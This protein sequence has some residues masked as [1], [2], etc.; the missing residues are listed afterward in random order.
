M[1]NPAFARPS[2]R[3]KVTG[4]REYI[5]PLI[6]ALTLAASILLVPAIVKGDARSDAEAIRAASG[7]AGGFVV[8]LG[9]T[10]GTMTAALR[11]SESFQ[12]QGLV[13]DAATLTKVRDQIRAA[14]IYGDVSADQFAGT[15]LPYVDNLVNLLVAESLGEV[16]ET[17]ALRVLVPN[18][19]LLVK[20][21][22]GEWTKTIKPRPADID[23]WSHYLHDAS[24][25]AVA[26]DKQVAPPRHLQWVGSPRWSRHHDR[27]ASMSALV[28]TNGRMFYIMDEGSRVSI[29][30]PSHWKLIAR[31]AFNGTILWKRDMVNWQ[32]HLWPLKSGPTQLSRRLVSNADTVFSTLSFDAPLTALDAATGKTVRT[33]EGT[34]GTEEVINTGGKLFLVVRKGPAELAEYAPANP[35]VGDQ[36]LVGTEFFWN[37]EPRVVMA[38]DEKTGEQLWAKQS[39]I[40]P[41]TLAADA[42][43][44][45]FH[46]GESLIAINQTSGEVAWKTEPVGRRKQ[47]TFNFGPRLVVHQDVVLYAGGDGNMVSVAAAD[48]KKLWSAEH[49]NSGYQSPQD[50]MVVD[51]L[52]WCAPTTS[53]KDT[54][55]YTGR[56]PK[57]GEVKKQFAPDVDTYWFHH[58]CY[59]AKATDNFLIPSRTGVEF[60]DYEKEHWDINHWVRGGCLYGVMPCNGL[61]Y[62][63]PHNC[64]CYPEAK[65]YG[66]NALAPMAPTRPIPA[67]VSEVGRLVKGSAFGQ[68]IALAT[69]TDGSD[70]WPTFRHDES[71]S[72]TSK[73]PIDSEVNPQWTAD[74]GGRL[75]SPVIAGGHVF[76]AQ[77]DTHTLYALNE[78]TGKQE[79]TYTAGARIDSPPTIHKGHVVFG[80]ADG[81][82]YCLRSADGQ[83]IW[84]YRAAPLDRRTMAYEQ[85]ESVWPVHGSV[86]IRD[87]TVYCVAGRSNFLDG[88]LR[89]LRLKVTTGEKLSETIMDE[90]HPDTGDNLQETLQILQMPVGLPDILSAD[91]KFLYMRSQKFDFEGK[92]LEIGPVSGDFVKQGSAQR[93]EGVHLFAPMGFLDDTWFHRSYWVFGKNFAGGHGGYYQAGKFTPSGRIMVNG[94]GYVYGYGRKPEYLRWTTTMEHQL[95]AASPTPPEIPENFAAAGGGQPSGAYAQFKASPSLDPTGK[96]LT[97]EAWIAANSPNGVIVARGGPAE[98]FALTLETGKPT[99]HIRAGGQLTTISGPK[100]IVGGWHHVVGVIDTDK[101]MRLHVDG[102]LAAE[103]VASSL[104][105]KDP[106]QGM[107]I[108]DDAAGSV[109]EYPSPFPFGGIIDEVRLY[110]TAVSAERIA[111][112][113]EDDS[114]L[115]G[116]PALVVS[117]DDGSARDLS[118]FR[119]NGTLEGGNVVE[120]HVGKGI[121][122]TNRPNAGTTAANNAS[123]ANPANKGKKNVAKGNKKNAA[124][125]AANAAV[126]PGDSL[127][128]PKWTTDVPIYVRGMVLAGPYLFIV[129]PPDIIDEEST[130]QKLT[131]KDPEVQELLSKQ[132]QAL[133]GKDGGLLL[134]VNADTGEVAHR[135]ELGT[136]PTWDGLA[137]A[138]G[139]LFLSTMNGKVMCFGK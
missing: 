107:E 113:Y 90:T 6:H 33:F 46:D 100:R 51:N 111:E 92:R 81:W 43:N 40:S 129:G 65:L 8:H 87:E 16:T 103:G 59:I 86:L 45:Y 134:A 69:S 39:R 124:N 122:F 23:E 89:L 34:D 49:P 58:R 57:T 54:G 98:G 35:T 119:N 70:D 99:F 104:I 10:D 25:N 79:W 114:E 95:F 71:R 38:F 48:G 106:A 24:G 55:V 73:Q 123:P 37:E 68:P 42:A 116:D 84:R 85:L 31:D 4:R 53:G 102:E 72:G 118:T 128:K 117:F 22:A 108:G 50:L 126:K 64:A 9:T 28:S 62:T 110:F 26:H 14:T 21:A 138:N 137:G 56:D 115:S 1:R 139:Q 13:T 76:V 32:S 30:L 63:P 135:V 127:V 2:C 75:T 77:I 3:L 132:D 133:D 52:V 96:A 91:S 82:V 94:D 131:E 60:V 121:Q 15:E 61:T 44:V 7:V 47:F 27:M 67:E 93:G 112:R 88:G 19:V 125:Q 11:G 41:L 130:F 83:L 17:E 109:G 20:N 74:L 136:L 36:K 105:S 12:V 29:Q 66:F 97:I 18:G 80:G 78:K 120:G 5:F 101:K